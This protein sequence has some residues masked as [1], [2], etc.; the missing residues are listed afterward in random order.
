MKKLDL[1]EKYYLFGVALNI[2]DKNGEQCFPK[3]DDCIESLDGLTTLPLVSLVT[4]LDSDEH[5]S[6]IWASDKTGVLC[7]LTNDIVSS[8]ATMPNQKIDLE[9]ST[10][11]LPELFRHTKLH[12]LNKSDYHLLHVPVSILSSLL[13]YSFDDEELVEKIKEYWSKGSLLT[14]DLWD[15]PGE[16]PY[17]H[18]LHTVRKNQLKGKYLG[19]NLTGQEQAYNDWFD[20][21]EDEST[22]LRGFILP[23]NDLCAVTFTDKI[24]NQ[25]RVRMFRYDPSYRPDETNEEDR[26]NIELGARNFHHILSITTA[27]DIN[28]GEEGDSPVALLKLPPHTLKNGF[29]TFE[30]EFTYQSEELIPEALKRANILRR[31]EEGNYI[32]SYELREYIAFEHHSPFGK[33]AMISG[34]MISLEESLVAQFPEYLGGVKHYLEGNGDYSK[35][36]DK[37]GRVL[38]S[39]KE[40]INATHAAGEVFFSEAQ[41]VL[42]SNRNKKSGE[43]PKLISATNVAKAFVG[44][45]DNKHLPQSMATVLDLGHATRAVR[46][47]ISSF[48]NLYKQ[49]QTHPK[50]YAKTV[51]LNALFSSKFIDVNQS[52]KGVLDAAKTKPEGEFE[53][54]G[55]L[56]ETWFQGIVDG[57]KEGINFDATYNSITDLFALFDQAKQSNSQA[58]REKKAFSAIA[59]DYLNR[60]PALSEERMVNVEL[61]NKMYSALK[62]SLVLV[63]QS[64]ANSDSLAIKKDVELN[65][66][67]QQLFPMQDDGGTGFQF[68]FH[69]NSRENEVEVYQPFF[70]A[71]AEQLKQYG[72]VRLIIE[73]HACQVDS[74]EVNIQ[75]SHERAENTKAAFGEDLASRIQ[76][77]SKG[78]DEPIYIPEPQDIRSDNPNLIANRRVVVRAY[79]PKFSLTFPASRTASKAME[80]ARCDTVLA[81]KK[82]LDDRDLFGTALLLFTLDM[83]QYIPQ[84]SLV[85]RGFLTLHSVHGHAESAYRKLEREVM[86]WMYEGY[87]GAP[88]QDIARM[89]EVHRFLLGELKRVEVDLEQQIQGGT[90]LK[91]LLSSE[92]SRLQIVKRYLKRAVA[93]SG[94]LLLLADLKKISSRANI[95]F[96]DVLSTYK[97]DDYIQQLIFDDAWSVYSFNNNDVVSTW[98]NFCQ[99]Q[100]DSLVAYQDSQNIDAYK[101]ARAHRYWGASSDNEKSFKDTFIHNREDP[102]NNFDNNFPVHC[103]LSDYSQEDSELLYD[104]CENFASNFNSVQERILTQSDIAFARVLIAQPTDEAESEV[105]WYEYKKWC[106][107]D[108]SN[109][110]S[111]FHKVKVQ[112]WVNEP[113][114]DKLAT[115]LIFNHLIGYQLSGIDIGPAFDVLFSPMGPEDFAVCSNSQNKDVDDEILKFYQMAQQQ[116]G[117]DELPRLTAMQFEFNY[118]FGP[119]NING[120]KPVLSQITIDRAY[121]RDLR[122]LWGQRA[123]TTVP[124]YRG[125]YEAFVDDGHF[126]QRD[127]KFVALTADRDR[128]DKYKQVKVAADLTGHKATAATGEQL[129]KI[130]LSFVSSLNYGVHSEDSYDIKVTCSGKQEKVHINE[131]MM[132][133]HQDFVMTQNSSQ[134]TY[135]RLFDGSATYAYVA[136]QQG[137]LKPESYIGSQTIRNFSWKESSNNKTRL[138]MA[139]FVDN[140]ND[141]DYEDNYQD[142]SRVDVELLLEL[143][144]GAGDKNNDL[145]PMLQGSL[146]HCG[147]V[148]HKSGWQWDNDDLDVESQRLLSIAEEATRDIN[149]KRRRGVDIDVFEASSTDR[150]KEFDVVHHKLD[151]RK[152]YHVFVVEFEL[153][154]VAPTGVK[155]DGLRPFG[156]ILTSQRNTCKLKLG[157]LKHK[158]SSITY[159]FISPKI[160]LPNLD[161]SDQD[162]PW[163]KLEGQSA[164]KVNLLQSQYWQRHA[165]K[166]KCGVTQDSIVEDWVVNQ[167]T[168]VYRPQWHVECRKMVTNLSSLCEAEDS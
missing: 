30:V 103:K 89:L 3:I 161:V 57:A 129:D 166:T 14:E 61:I 20:S 44:A 12:K 67:E 39:Q 4:D 69:F 146:V 84:V 49:S 148:A 27:A 98:K 136:I 24:Y 6:N 75:V 82:Q 17:K 113:N 116:L 164:N 40:I 87:N 125:E 22:E 94:L 162:M 118:W 107:E 11:E 128:Q 10:D 99:S 134:Q 91:E 80:K 115:G 83:V 147:K 97:V 1:T 19:K 63:H 15:E 18:K 54:F 58:Q 120:I 43:E 34:D 81:T 62:E 160:G 101:K 165:Q 8:G 36:T 56:A 32:F 78:F 158:G 26:L 74:S 143:V 29:Y 16:N 60:I 155:L 64:L 21:I 150:E 168:N 154:Y 28:S 109:R 53:T 66:T 112:V 31:V 7:N 59:G 119:W 105:K 139:L 124:K 88:I 102:L 152:E 38:L 144:H 95:A 157:S 123:A 79:I 167:G 138:Q 111:P 133:D 142:W 33:F 65:A 135:H 149:L 5:V 132:L 47:D 73:G 55:K 90:K 51:G 96:R 126:D 48:T 114:S 159:D 52:L 106:K 70:D 50:R 92:N 130:G 137:N 108:K 86:E 68:H 41:E 9:S 77:F 100:D 140:L 117:T 145:G 131:Q 25:A 127:L 153:D 93:F 72:D 2:V 76:T 13:P 104:L 163:R 35:Q 42:R 122:E 46:D 156:R 121:P 37:L 71:F 151:Q 85:A 23:A 110:L 141:E 45:I